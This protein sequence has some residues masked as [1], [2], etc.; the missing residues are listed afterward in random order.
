MSKIIFLLSAFLFVAC[1]SDN[2]QPAVATYAYTQNGVGNNRLCPPQ[3]AEDWNRLVAS[4]CNSPQGEEGARWC[5]WG[6]REFQQRNSAYIQ[7]PGCAIAVAQTQWCPG[8]NWRGQQFYQINEP[9]LQSGIFGQYGWAA[10][11]TWPVNGG[12]R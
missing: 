7:G 11:P 2:N 10:G 9:I 4:R 8:D 3:T 12:R 1:G 5:Y 6:A